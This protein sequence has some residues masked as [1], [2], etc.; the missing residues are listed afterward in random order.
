MTKSE[1]RKLYKQKRENL[2]SES[3]ENLSIDIA[4][5]AIRAGIWNFNTYHLFLSIDRLKEIDTTYLLSVIQGKDKEVVISRSDFNDGTM[6]H[7]LLTDNT[8][9]KPNRFG[10]PEPIS[11][12]EIKPSQLDVVFIPLLAY[13]KK[14]NRVGYGKGFYDRFLSECNK[15][16]LKVGLSFFPPCE[17]ITGMDKNDIPLDLCVTPTGVYDFRN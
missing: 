9:I 3:I 8:V 15:E 2:S 16:T 12:L 10:I 5:N 1:L 4:N 13:D 7:F 6:T 14:G 11:G 17:N